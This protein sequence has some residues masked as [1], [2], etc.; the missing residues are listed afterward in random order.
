MRVEVRAKPVNRRVRSCGIGCL[1]LIVLIVGSLVYLVPN[2]IIP[3]FETGGGNEDTR[4]VPGDARRFDP[5]AALPGVREYAGVGAKL[6][7]L[8]ADYV[9]SDGTL[10]LN[11][12][13]TPKPNVDY[14][15]IR[16]VARPADAAP[17]GAGGSNTGPWYEPIRIRAYQPG[18]WRQV[19]RSGGGVSLRYSYMNRGMERDAGAP[20]TN[21]ETVAPDPACSLA[22]LWQVALT[23]DAPREAVAVIEYDAA[24]YEFRISGLSVDLGFDMDCKL[25]S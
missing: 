19:T 6:V 12:D 1:A 10:D 3:F 17:I 24:G 9:R 13:Y 15:F 22:D 16:E 2:V 23:K 25:K 4:P 21:A 8:R 11:A 5:I 14:R 20:T 18:Q 7:S